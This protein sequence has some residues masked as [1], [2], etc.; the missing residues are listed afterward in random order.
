MM[1]T[2]DYNLA[3]LL[4]AAIEVPA[5]IN[6]MLFPSKQLGKDTPNA[7]P[8]V[9]QYA[10]LLVASVLI[11][12]VFAVRETDEISRVVAGCLAIYHPGPALRSFARLRNQ[13][14]RSEPLLASEAF[15]YLICHIL[16]GSALILCYFDVDPLKI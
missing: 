13:Y 10:L 1:P 4:H 8:V 3:F 7:H 12:I 9:R 6:F 5:A 15:L 11:A 2:M 16:T 14:K